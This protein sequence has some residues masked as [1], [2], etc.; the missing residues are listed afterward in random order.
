MNV[1]NLDRRLFS[2]KYLQ[3]RKGAS[4]QHPVDS[5]KKARGPVSVRKDFMETGSR[6]AEVSPNG[7]LDGELMILWPLRLVGCWSSVSGG[8]IV[9]KFLNA[10][11]FDF[12][13]FVVSGKV[14]I[15]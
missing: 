4:G 8:R 2:W 10:C 14:G 12:T 6:N 1:R 9:N 15:L 13:A 7:E 11:P 3:E 5:I